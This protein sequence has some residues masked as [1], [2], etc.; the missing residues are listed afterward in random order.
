MGSDVVTLTMFHICEF[1]GV[2][3]ATGCCVL[4]GLDISLAQIEMPRG[5]VF[6]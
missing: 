4:G 6:G 2:S 1:T 3:V 5:A